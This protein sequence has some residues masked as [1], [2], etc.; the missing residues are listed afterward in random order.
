MQNQ[1]LPK[2]ITTAT[3]VQAKKRERPGKRWR[4]EVKEDLNTI[5]M[6]NRQAM[7]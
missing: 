3:T 2:Q 5:G 4:D 1:Q 6:G 7:V